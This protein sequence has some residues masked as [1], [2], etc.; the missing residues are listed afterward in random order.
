MQTFAARYYKTP[1]RRGVGYRFVINEAVLGA[2]R[3]QAAGVLASSKFV[4]LYSN[5]S[6]CLINIVVRLLFG[7]LPA[8]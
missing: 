3:A 7:N 1:T 5:V 4:E 6:I 2:T 8:S